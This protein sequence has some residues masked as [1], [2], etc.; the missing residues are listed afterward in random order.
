L[1]LASAELARGDLAGAQRQLRL[2][3]MDD[4]DDPALWLALGNLQ[5]SAEDLTGAAESYREAQGLAPD[6]ADAH[7]LG[8]LVVKLQDG[9]TE[10]K[11]LA[12]AALAIQPRHPLALKVLARVQLDWGNQD[13]AEKYCDMILSEDPAD[14][15]ARTI[16]GQCRADTPSL[17]P[18]RPGVGVGYDAYISLGSNCEAGL[19]FRRF[20]YEES[21]FF[22]F[23]LS[24]F[25]A[26]FAALES[27]FAGM[28][29]RDNIR[30]HTD[31]M[32]HDIGSGITFHSDLKSAINPQSGRR[33]FLTEYDFDEVYGMNERPKIRHLI[34]KWRALTQSQQNVLYFLKL[35]DENPRER[36]LCMADL[37]RRKYPGHQWT[38][39]CFQSV[40]PTQADWNI[41]GVINRYV[42]RF[43][44]IGNAYDADLQAW[45]RIFAEFALKQRPRPARL[46]P[47]P[48]PT[49]AS[50]S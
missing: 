9:S 48:F 3:L 25:A 33:E 31:G 41:P 14:A 26:T 2:G 16:R 22:R 6:C 27:D 12:L 29:K 23:T 37:F 17:P 30:P 19:Q 36:A 5:L 47:M 42:S 44:P 28:F 40:D 45:D 1:A 10:A 4:A 38:M 50:A 11:R 34:A 21:S 32:V 46:P 35:D 8:A 7:A 24:S 39:L 13:L 43:A 20:G 18:P 15:D 49:F